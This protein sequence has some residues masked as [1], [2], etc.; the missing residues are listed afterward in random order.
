MSIE[1]L[2]DDDASTGGRMAG[3]L[4]RNLTEKLRSAITSEK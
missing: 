4:L 3:Q 2:R 1:H